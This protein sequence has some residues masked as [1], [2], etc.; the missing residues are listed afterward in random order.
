MKE[1]PLW[2]REP[3]ARWLD[4]TPIGNGRLGGMVFGGLAQERIAL[5]HENL[6]RGMT[7]NLPHPAVSQHL[8]E[9]R[10]ALLAGR[11][12]E[13]GELA[14]RHFCQPDLHIDPYQPLGDLRL[15]LPGH[16]TADDYR[17]ELD[18]AAGVVT[19]AYRLGGIP[20]RRECFASAVHGALI[21]RLGAGRSGC[22]TATVALNRTPDPDCS[23]SHWSRAD[24]IGFTGRFKEGVVFAAEARLLVR[25]GRVRPAPAGAVEIE[26]ADEVL[27]ALTAGTDYA[28]PDPAA[29]CRARL[30]A[31]PEDAGL[32]RELHEAEHRS[33]VGRVSLD[34]A[35]D[36]ALDVLSTDE[37]LAR[38]RAGA[39]D[40]GLTAQYFQFGR[41]LLAASSRPSTDQPANLQGLWNE[42]LRPPWN[43]DFH[44]DVNLQMNYWPAE[45]CNLS[46]CAEPLF[47][48]LRRMMPAARQA[49]R[50]A[51]GCRGIYM[52]GAGDIWPR[53]ALGAPGYDPWTGALAWLAQ[54]LWWRY[55]FSLDRGF[56]RDQAYPFLKEVALFYQD[57]LVRD[58]RGRLVTVPSQ[59]PENPFA[60]G[61]KPASL[62]VAATMDLLLIREVMERCL[63]ASQLLDTDA[64]MRPAWQAILDDLPPYQT[65]RHGQLQ[66]W[67]EDFDEVDPG[68]RHLS[69]LIGV[70][71]GDAMTPERQPEAYRAMRTALERRCA[72]G[73]GQS[74]WSAAWIACLWARFND[75]DQAEAYLQRLL[76]KHTAPSLLD[77]Y[78][79]EIFQIDGN[80]GG[81]AA[82]AEMLVQSHEGVIRLLPALPAAW[83]AGRVRGLRARG[84]WELDIAWEDS[85][86][87][88][89]VLRASV[90]GEAA[91]G[92][93]P[94]LRVVERTG[95][96]DDRPVRAE[97]GGGNIIRFHAAAGRRYR[98]TPV[99]PGESS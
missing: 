53:T 96:G 83:P 71:P 20:H 72:A 42:S 75:G 13:A 54:H 31:I 87:A 60:G 23:V 99:Q 64:A 40:P 1:F 92:A 43:S 62:C 85:A 51:F 61:S 30:A 39:G 19:V 59:S 94:C 44:L 98:L 8:P 52:L 37:R 29:A 57:F 26:N 14:N 86:V 16:E 48:F 11:W 49:A 58:S 91:V 21:V 79:P 56:L 35:H 6:W 22:I 63:Q 32:L 68:H 38:V 7:R 69:H 17:R 47:R 50:D 10:E 73:S 18:L 46:D 76:A 9:L 66:E 82:V 67:L 77:L 24:G 95:D 34:L 78:P 88:E 45:V 81:T 2:W 12:L 93:A 25:G 4:A 55:E 65:G 33:F 70:F 5:N 97:T 28:D 41:Y 80:F 90:D 27:V 15:D 84:G 3:A 36:P 89:A 74:G